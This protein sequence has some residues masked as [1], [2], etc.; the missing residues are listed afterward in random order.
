M[1]Y[2][3]K[4]MMIEAFQMTREHRQ[5]TSSWPEWLNEA[6]QRNRDEI[7]AVYRSAPVSIGM[8]RFVLVTLGGARVIYW[9]Y[10]IMQ[11]R[12][13]RLLVCDPNDFKDN[14]DIVEDPAEEDEF[15]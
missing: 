9:N 6:C 10:Y 8:G 2:K 7:G 3:K 15:I 4:S 11:R 12:D 1:K 5:D 13:G 14:Y